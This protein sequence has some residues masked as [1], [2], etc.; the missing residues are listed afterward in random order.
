MHPNGGELHCF[1]FSV[2]DLW[3]F[4]SKNVLSMWRVEWFHVDLDETPKH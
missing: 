4:D 2:H 1:L 3:I